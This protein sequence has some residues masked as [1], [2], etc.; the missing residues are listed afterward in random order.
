[1]LGLHALSTAKATGAEKE[2]LTFIFMAEQLKEMKTRT[3]SF[4]A[5]VTI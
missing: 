5:S 3:R 2:R 4:K 1:V